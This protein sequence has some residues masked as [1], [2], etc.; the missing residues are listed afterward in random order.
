MKFV[1]IA[2]AATG[3]TALQGATDACTSQSVGTM[4]MLSMKGTQMGDVCEA[5]CKRTGAYP[6]CQCAG[7]NGAPA[8]D[9]DTRACMDKYCQDPKAPC[10][11][12]GF[13]GC[14]KENTKVSALQWD[15]VFAQ[16]SQ[17]LDALKST[18]RMGKGSSAQEACDSKKQVGFTALMQAKAEQMGVDCEAMCKRIGIYPNCQCAGFNGAPSSDGDTRACMDK[19]CQDPSAPCPNDAF[20]GCVKE[21]T[22]VSVLQWDAVFA[23]VSQGLD[24]LK[25]TVAMG[26]GKAAEQA[27]DGQK[28][29]G[30]SA[31][32]QAKAAQMGDKCEAMCKRIGAY[33]N[34][35]CAGFNGAPASDGDTRA[36]MTK[37]CQDPSAP[38]PN[39]A[40]VGCVKE[41]TK[42]SALQWAA[43]F[44]QV[45]GGLDS[46]SRMVKLGKTATK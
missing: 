31:L 34:C 21:N 7:F 17:G 22:A 13:V 16:V 29:L 45:S 4:A 5:M 24:A 38:C 1:V 14:V 25:H 44:E 42:V 41:N 23:Q 36:C 28:Q 43:V 26:K 19:Y 10:P 35:Q 12:D 8:S 18:V 37:Y 3:A 40:F 6:N 15:A 27:C 33:P 46:L 30:F 9:G 32:L 11:N 39:D 2:L 20:V